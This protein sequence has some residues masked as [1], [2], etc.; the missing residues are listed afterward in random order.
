[1]DRQ[2]SIAQAK[3]H[4]SEIVQAAERGEVVVVTRRGKPVVRVV[5]DADYGKLVARR[6]KIDW[7]EALVDTR[8][9]RFNREEANER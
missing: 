7:G 8:G 2:V 6:K 9:F 3:D 4:F 1:M 5:S